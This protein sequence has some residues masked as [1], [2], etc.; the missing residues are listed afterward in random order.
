MAMGVSASSE[1][2][3]LGSMS[4]LPSVAP[5]SSD[6]EILFIFD[7]D[8]T[9]T[10]RHFWGLMMGDYKV[11]P[12]DVERA[13]FLKHHYINQSGTANATIFDDIPE[14][15]KVQLVEYIFGSIDRLK[16]I[17]QFLCRLR[18]VAGPG[19]R[20]EIWTRSFKSQV[21]NLLRKDYIDLFD[22][23]DRIR[24]RSH[25]GA[26]KSALLSEKMRAKY[27]YIFIFED[28]K[29]EFNFPFVQR[30]PGKLFKS[31]QNLYLFESADFKKE[32]SGIVPNDDIINDI[33]AVLI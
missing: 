31:F 18:E 4:T 1:G 30:S 6:R 9:I 29:S 24:D 13:S 16:W 28:S 15:G 21:E 17:K 8:C 11:K 14:G 7:F 2:G 23:I 10:S 12:E 27:P 32:G 5:T 22:C 25:F 33:A 3:R 19:A 26:D 20:I